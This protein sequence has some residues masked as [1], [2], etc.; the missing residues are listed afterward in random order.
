[1]SVRVPFS[2]HLKPK[3]PADGCD[4]LKGIGHTRLQLL[5]SV[6]FFSLNYIRSATM[7]EVLQLVRNCV[8]NIL[9]VVDSAT[10]IPMFQVIRGGI[11]LDDCQTGALCSVSLGNAELISLASWMRVE[12]SLADLPFNG[13]HGYILLSSLQGLT[14]LNGF[15]DAGL[16]TGY[17]HNKP[18]TCDLK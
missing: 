9:Q 15:G 10:I 2:V 4:T 14:G 7:P 12:G 8:A 1:M 17:F 18:Q 16:L 3:V 11:Y 6:W 13:D 5:C